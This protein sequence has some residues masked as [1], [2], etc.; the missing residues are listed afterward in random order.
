MFDKTFKAISDPIRRDILFYLKEQ[1]LS[2]GDIAAKFDISA[3]SVSYHLNI[4]K[5]ADLVRETKYKNYIYYSLNISV[6]EEMILWFKTF[7]R[8]DNSHEI[9]A[10]K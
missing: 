10:K 7:L 1:D 6:F 9:N 4:L 3:P 8:E 5:K 2:A